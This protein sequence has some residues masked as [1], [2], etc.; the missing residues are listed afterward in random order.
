MPEP[1]KVL[2]FSKTLGYRHESIEAG[3]LSFQK[4]AE[5]STG[6]DHP[7]TVEASE[8]AEATFAPETL[9]RFRVIVLLHASGNFLTSEQL[10]VLERQVSSGES[11]IVGIHGA[12]SAMLSR[13]VDP[14]GYYGRLLGAVFTEHPA[15]QPG[16]VVIKAP[17]HPIVQPFLKVVS[18]PSDASLPEPSFSHF[19][20]W[21]NYEPTSCAVV[22]AQQTPTTPTTES[23]DA[24]HILLE[25]DETTYE[26][27]KHGKHHPIAWTWPDFEGTG[28]RVYYTALGHFA[29]AYEDEVFVSHL[30]TAVLWAAKVV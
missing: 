21:Y 2:V 27:G 29:E 19:D 28:T 18:A 10:A 23:H 20:E 11:G 9:A 25:A 15:P 14:A 12:S 13:E 4:L 22:A 6:S 17:Q 5:Q 8:D 1:F 24:T 30:K 26:G 16:R 3:I 7:F